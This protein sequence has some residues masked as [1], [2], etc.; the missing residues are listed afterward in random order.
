[1]EAT[2]IVAKRI[3]GSGNLIADPINYFDYQNCACIFANDGWG[4]RIVP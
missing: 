4:S 3:H 1:M 2:A